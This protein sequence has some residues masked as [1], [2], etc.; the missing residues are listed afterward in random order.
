M[1]IVDDI[2]RRRA[3]NGEIFEVYAV[4]SFVIAEFKLPWENGSRFRRI[5]PDY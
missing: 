4:K 1:K 3:V 2:N 5:S